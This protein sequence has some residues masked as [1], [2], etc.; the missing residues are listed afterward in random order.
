MKCYRLVQP[1]RTL[2][3]TARPIQQNIL[4][5]AMETKADELAMYKDG[6]KLIVKSSSDSFSLPLFVNKLICRNEI[7]IKN[8]KTK[9]QRYTYDFVGYLSAIVLKISQEGHGY[10]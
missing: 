2:V 5:Y 10:L 3:T 9:Q 7:Q 6:Y 8:H 1:D 4:C